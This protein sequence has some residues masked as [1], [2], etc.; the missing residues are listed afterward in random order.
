MLSRYTT[1][2]LPCGVSTSNILLIVNSLTSSNP[3]CVK[4]RCILLLLAYSANFIS[5][6]AVSVLLLKSVTYNPLIIIGKVSEV[7]TRILVLCRVPVLK[8]SYTSCMGANQT[9][10]I[11]RSLC[12][13]MADRT[14]LEP[15][16][17]LRT[18][19]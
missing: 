3:Y 19:P 10:L 5:A 14:G 18:P 4:S 15:A 12:C 11:R 8:T 2:Y 6:I 16:M 17:C 13:N 9:S 7:R 1:L